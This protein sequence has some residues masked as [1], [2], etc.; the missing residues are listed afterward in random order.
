MRWTHLCLSLLIV[1]T[2]LARLPAAET[3]AKPKVQGYA[4]QRVSEKL[5]RGVVATRVDGGKVYVS[6]R[7]L[8]SDPKDV[9]FDVFRID[10]SDTA[11]YQ[12]NKDVV[13]TPEK[14]NKEPIR[15]TTD[16]IDTAAPAGRWLPVHCVH[17]RPAGRPARHARPGH[18]QRCC[19]AL[20]ID[21]TP[22]RLHLSKSRHWRPRR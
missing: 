19:Q 7:L 6:W 14:L 18:L 9:A 13:A 15:Q 12:I 5:D 2:S 21:Q 16:F 11:K 8:D 20:P 10:R 3:A 22:G 17:C 1:T 4:Q